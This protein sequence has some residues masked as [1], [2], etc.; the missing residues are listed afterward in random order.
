MGAWG[1][2]KARAWV[3]GRKDLLE[4]LQA[5]MRQNEA[6]VVWVH[7]AS[8]G[9]FEQAKP[10][11]EAITNTFPQYKILAT[12]FSPSGYE[13][14]ANYAHIHYRYYLPLD[15][16]ANAQRFLGAVKPT[17]VIFSKYDFWHHFINGVHKA[18]IPLLLVSARFRESQLFFKPFGGFYRTM[19]HRFTHLFVQDF[20][21]EKLLHQIGVHHCSVTGD[22]RFDR[23]ADIVHRPQ[24]NNVALDLIEQL[25]TRKRPCVVA[26]STWSGDEALL[27]V[28]HQKLEGW[29][30]LVVPHE[31]NKPHI[32]ELK[33]RFPDAVALS[34]VQQALTVTNHPSE[35]ATQELETAEAFINT[36]PGK[37]VFIIDAMGLLSRLY[38]Q[39]TIT[40]VGGGFTRDGV[41]NTLEAAVWGR[42]VLI[43]PNYVKYLE[44]KEMVAQGAAFSFTNETELAAVLR[45]LAH[46]K[47]A[48]A[49]ASEKARIYVAENAGAT[50][51]IMDY[52]QAK[53]L[54]TN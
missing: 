18:G 22:T 29:C 20:L 41:H 3:A 7:N 40:Y 11:I 45:E 17:L 46:N 36:L 44:A 12:F 28:V 1:N 42:P 5:S 47:A 48:L 25:M 24:Q 30:W 4:T 54:L 32:A 10:V 19:L 49:A 2:P 26:G 13:A 9:E 16:R 34:E 51:K 6:P 33:S 37:T 43:G 23:V 31:I 14:A 38:A 52:I 21:S 15:T 39:A 50:Q 53:R 35:H 8:T 27:A